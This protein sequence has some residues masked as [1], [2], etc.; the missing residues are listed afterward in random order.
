MDLQHHIKQ[1]LLLPE[2]NSQAC[3]HSFFE[4]ADCHACVDACSKQ[5]WLL[6]DEGLG[7]DT[8]ACDGCGLCVPSCPGGALHITFPW[9]IRSFNEQTFVLFGCDQSGINKANSD[10][11]PCI[12][13]LGLRQLL[14]IY[15]SGIEYLLISTGKCDKC[16]HFPSTDI[17]QHLK[18][19]NNLLSERD[20]PPLKILH[21]SN[22]T[23]EKIFASEEVN[24]QGTQLSRRSFLRGG[25]KVIRQQ[26]AIMDTLNIPESRTIPPGQLLTTESKEVHWPWVP[27]INTCLCNG[28]DTCIKLCPTEALQLIPE[29]DNAFLLVYSINPQNCIGCGIC[30]IICESQAISVQKWQQSSPHHISLSEALCSACGNDFHLPQQNPQSNKS[31][32][33]I[34]SQHNHGHNLFQRLS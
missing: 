12:H 5:A 14:L 26:L 15:N 9:I 21:H 28:C 10:L 27:K 18:Q 11:L 25:G 4:Q 3:V 19:V 29:K 24:N 30:E 13:A 22:K 7:L 32:C 31:L 23:W 1:E 16:H 34:C 8:N 20:K 17:Y 33:R 6:D 2:I